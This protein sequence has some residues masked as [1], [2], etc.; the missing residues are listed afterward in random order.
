MKKFLITCGILFGIL[1]IY[2]VTI[3]LF[4]RYFIISSEIE[5]NV[6][7]TAKMTYIDSHGRFSYGWGNKSCH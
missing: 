6:P 2:I 5:I 4:G 1:W 7:I 3:I